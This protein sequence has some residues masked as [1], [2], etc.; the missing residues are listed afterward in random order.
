MNPD[1]VDKKQEQFNLK[2]VN[3]ATSFFK[4]IGLPYSIVPSYQADPP[5][6]FFEGCWLS[7][8]KLHFCPK[9]VQVGELLHE[10]AHLAL[11][12]KSMWNDLKPGNLEVET[13]YGD[14]GAEAWD[15]AAAAFTGI[16]FFVV[17]TKGFA[18][19][20][21]D[22]LQLFDLGIHPGIRL[23]EEGGLASP[24]PHM[25]R[26]FVKDSDLENSKVV[27]IPKVIKSPKKFDNS[28]DM[29]AYTQASSKNL[30][31]LHELASEHLRQGRLLEAGELLHQILQAQPNN[32]VALHDVGAI[33]YQQGNYQAALSLVTKALQ[34]EP[35]L[36]SA[37]YTLGN[38]L[39]LQG[40]LDEAIT[41]YRKSLSLKPS[42]AEAHYGLGNALVS[43]GK[44]DEAI[45]SYRQALML[46][47]GFAEAY[48]SLGNAWVS[49]GKLEEGIA[50]Y[51]QALALRPNFAEAHY[52]LG[53]ALVSQGKLTEAIVSYRQA[54][55]LKPQ[56]DWAGVAHDKLRKLTG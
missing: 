18:G 29:G 46:Q 8:G 12:P 36:P 19:Q 15:Y 34:L 32:A 55:A 3:R 43:Q 50:S 53:D 35:N 21:W 25:R 4:K 14:P 41:S 23:L 20:N 1:V 49:Q 13:L 37:N 40:K 30:K 48:Y 26:W 9:R 22:I 33:L 6:T 47:P 2:W 54:L 56:S 28:L 39:S 11:L 17:F 44:L 38:L 42:F 10:A 7:A 31:Q 52:V 24:F 45:T 16:P 51:Q 5:G 27:E